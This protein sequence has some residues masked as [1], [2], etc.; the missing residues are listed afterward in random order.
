VKG[1]DSG[2]LF[3]TGRSWIDIQGLKFNPEVDRFPISLGRE[4]NFPTLLDIEA[5]GTIMEGAVAGALWNTNR[6][7]LKAV[8]FGNGYFGPFGELKV[9]TTLPSRMAAQQI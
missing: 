7:T 1:F 8:N 9:S 2:R 6:G 3:A 4:S 5:V